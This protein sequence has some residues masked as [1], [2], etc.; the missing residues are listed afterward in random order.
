MKHR[1]SV[2]RKP[3][4]LLLIIALIV[5]SAASSYA[6]DEYHDQIGYGGYQYSASELLY[7]VV[8]ETGTAV[9]AGPS[10]FDLYTESYTIPESIDGYPVTGIKDLSGN[11]LGAVTI[12]DCIRRLDGNPFAGSAVTQFTVSAEHPCFTTVDGV[13]LSKDGKRLIAFPDKYPAETYRIPDGVQVIGEEA[14][15]GCEVPSVIIPDSVTDIERGAF[16]NY[17]KLTSVVIPESVNTVKGNPF[18][19]VWTDETNPLERVVISPDHPYLEIRDGVLFS[20]PDNRLICYPKTD[21]AEVCEI[22][23]GT[24]AIADWA[25]YNCNNLKTVIFPDSLEEIGEDA[26]RDCGNLNTV[27]LPDGLRKIGARAFYCCNELTSIQIPDGI[28]EIAQG[29]FAE[30]TQLASVTIPDSVRKIGEGAFRY[31]ISLTTVHIPDGVTTIMPETFAGSG[32]TAVTIPDSVTGLTSWAFFGCQDL[33]SVSIPDG[34]KAIGP[35]VFHGCESLTSITLPEGLKSIGREAFAY[36]GLVSV[37]IPESVEK[38][39]DGAFQG[40]NLAKVIF[41]NERIDDI[42]NYVFEDCPDSLVIEGAE[43]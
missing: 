16:A 14:F 43:F 42:G 31:C 10:D 3:A 30:C 24:Q 25:F 33:S 29:M 12:P 27:E 5:C 17:G 41:Q 11:T 35:H 13:L 22:P 19:G 28:T 23:E 39:E 37:E 15:Y 32:L 26:F 34:I 40:A 6:W 36:S 21:P 18:A 7:Y 9:I 2:F 4:A 8:T 1:L 38:I 20:K